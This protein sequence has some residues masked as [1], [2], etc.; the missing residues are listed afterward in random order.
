MGSNHHRLQRALAATGAVLG[1][2]IWAP[3]DA[4]ATLGGDTSS[5]QANQEH[6]GAARQVARN[7]VFERHE[8]LLP[9]GILVREYVSPGGK[10]YAV[11]WRGSTMPDLRE[12]LGPYFDQLGRS[13]FRA[14]EGVHRL[15]VDGTDLVV[16]ASG[17]RGSFSGRAWVPSLVPPGV[18]PEV[19]LDAAR[20]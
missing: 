1:L 4:G 6:L 16:R 20:P 13:E 5:V 11:D 7:G 14:R 2:C 19:S 9:S 17:H 12:L 15:T 8:L 3:R 10:V 18:R